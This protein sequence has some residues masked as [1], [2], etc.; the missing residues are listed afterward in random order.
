[1]KCHCEYKTIL[2]RGT[3][4]SLQTKSTKHT[5]W[6]PASCGQDQNWKTFR[7]HLLLC[8][9]GRFHEDQEDRVHRRSPLRR[10]CSQSTGP[11]GDTAA[12]STATGLR[13]WA[14]RKPAVPS[15]VWSLLLGPESRRHL[16]NKQHENNLQLDPKQF[17]I[18]VR[19]LESQRNN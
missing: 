9:F 4:S 10:G 14:S 3:V 2:C 18:Y 5:S 6:S 8:T 19:M 13:V 17:L 16:G 15:L 7:S 11:P 1:M 12:W